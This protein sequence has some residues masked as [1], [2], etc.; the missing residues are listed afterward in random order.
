VLLHAAFIDN[1]L[2]NRFLVSASIWLLAALCV[3]TGA[4]SAF[5]SSVLRVSYAW[6]PPLFSVLGGAVLSF[7]LFAMAGFLLPAVPLMVSAVASAVPVLIVRQRRAHADVVALEREREEILSRLHNREERVAALERE[8]AANGPSESLER[9]QALTDELRRTREEVRS[10]SSRADDMSPFARDGTS[11]S[12]AAELFEGMVYSR[13]GPL[14]P[15]VEFVRRIAPSDAPVLILGES[16]TG[17]EL[18]ARAIHRLSPRGKE[19]FVAVNCGALAENLLESELFGHERGAFTG[20]VKDRAGRFEMAD[21]GTIFL[22]EIGETS[23]SFQVKLLRVLQEGEFERVGGSS[24]IRVHVRVLAA[25][26]RD[27]RSAVRDGRIRED[28]YYRLNV[29]SVSLPALRERAD[30]IPHLVLYFMERETKPIRLSNTVMEALR[31]FPW[32]GNIRELESTVRRAV[33][34]ATSD[35]RDII[36]LKDLPDEVAVAAR[37]SVPLE[38]QIL[39]SLRRKGFSRSSVSDTADELGGLNRGTVAEYLRGEVLKAFCEESFDPEAAARAV[40]MSAEP[41]VQLRVRKRL[42]EYL[43]N[44]TGGVDRTIGWNLVFLRPKVKNLPQRYHPY[45]ERIA[46]AFHKGEWTL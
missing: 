33:L 9:F 26:N 23:E 38:M 45:A 39:D 12:G 4:A 30:D 3:V 31:A 43:E 6:L 15:V 42:T 18:V 20:A 27:I 36:A 16:G 14:H 24:T 44:L 29:L 1:V 32:P 35:G 10:L 13:A 2:Q 46:E 28:L 34:L 25:T 22:D 37:A 8:L 17:K 41:D 11:A 5:G 40:S 21:G 7:V 19:P